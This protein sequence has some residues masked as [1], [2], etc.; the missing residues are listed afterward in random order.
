MNSPAFWRDIHFHSSPLPVE[1]EG[2]PNGDAHSDGHDRVPT[3]QL[4]AH[5]NQ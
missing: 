4:S 5:A 2:V 3:L 1:G